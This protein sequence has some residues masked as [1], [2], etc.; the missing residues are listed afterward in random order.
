MLNT[1]K[2]RKYSNLSKQKSYKL[3]WTLGVLTKANVVYLLVNAFATTYSK[4]YR[5]HTHTRTKSR[6][7]KYTQTQTRTEH[8]EGDEKNTKK[9]AV[10]ENV[11][12]TTAEHPPHAH[13]R[14]SDGNVLEEFEPQ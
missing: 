2:T 5:G 10:C 1:C 9:E 11:R 13:Q 12:D 6:T 14:P 8:G 7:F 3:Q 4:N